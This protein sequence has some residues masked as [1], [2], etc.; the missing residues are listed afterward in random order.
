VSPLFAQTRGGIFDFRRL[1]YIAGKHQ[2]FTA[3]PLDFLGDFH[4]L[5][6]AARE[7]SEGRTAPPQL[8]RKRSANAARRA[9]D[10]H[11]LL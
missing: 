10:K 5:L 3:A 2:R 6:S 9:G 4:Q 1:P 7:K 8:D 11:Y